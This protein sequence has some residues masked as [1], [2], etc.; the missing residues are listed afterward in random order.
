MVKVQTD[1]TTNYLLINNQS[2]SIPTLF[3]HGFTGTHDSW[4][5]IVDKL[6]YQTITLDIAG[7][8]KSYFLDRNFKYDINDWCN[9]FNDILDM[10]NIHKIKLC[11]YSMGG[12]LAIAFAS[13][14][15]YKIEKLIIES[16]SW[17]IKDSIDKKERYKEDLLLSKLIEEDL[18]EFARKWQA[19]PLFLK[20]KERN[21]IA[22]LNQQKTRLSQDSLQ[23]SKAL[24]IF[25]QGNMDS[26]KDEFKKFNFPICIINGSEDSKY[27]HLG[28]KMEEINPRAKQYVIDN[29][30]HNV[31]LEAPDAFIQLIK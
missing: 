12:R 5:H 29:A 30:N 16:S 3:L 18:T 8:G 22:F 25:S 19:N 11:G 13:K 27:I 4:N 7:H 10:L 21:S 1:K 15:P 2:K 14:Y 17:G 20:Q 6:D 28:R 9:D 26:Y 24:K 31:H 23:L